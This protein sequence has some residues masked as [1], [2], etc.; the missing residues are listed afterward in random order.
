M[1]FG[2]GNTRGRHDAMQDVRRQDAR[3]RREA[4]EA[5]AVR[6]RLERQGSVGGRANRLGTL[7]ALATVDALARRSLEGTMTAL[8]RSA[9]GPMRKAA[10]RVRDAGG[11]I[12]SDPRTEAD[13]FSGQDVQVFSVEQMRALAMAQVLKRY[14]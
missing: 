5:R 4:D 11:D 8:R 9:Q 10:D 7:A 14:F 2:R 1:D 3:A 12:T 6:D 13:H